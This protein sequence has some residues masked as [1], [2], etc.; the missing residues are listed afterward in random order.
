MPEL[1]IDTI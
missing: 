1:C